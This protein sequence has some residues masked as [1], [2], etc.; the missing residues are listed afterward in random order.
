MQLAVELQRQ[1]RYQRAH[2]VT[3]PNDRVPCVEK[4]GHSLQNPG[5]TE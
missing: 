1:P 3:L 5:R 4:M 2:M